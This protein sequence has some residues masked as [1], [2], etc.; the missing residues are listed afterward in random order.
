MAYRRNG[1][2]ERVYTAAAI[3]IEGTRY[4]GF[5]QPD[6]D[7]TVVIVT[8]RSTPEVA[9][10]I[11]IQ[12]RASEGISNIL[13]ESGSTQRM[14]KARLNPQERELTRFECI[15]SAL[16]P[17]EESIIFNRWFRFQNGSIRV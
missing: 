8:A 3:D 6:T 13:Y 9:F 16:E 1:E 7:G 15:T 10:D 12:L 2:T 5:Y 11:F 14:A 17:E 4:V